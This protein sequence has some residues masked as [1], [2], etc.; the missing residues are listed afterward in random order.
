[1]CSRLFI[2]PQIPIY[3]SQHPHLDYISPVFHLANNFV[4]NSRCVISYVCVK[5]EI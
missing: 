1:M 4:S 2:S 5:N 3:S